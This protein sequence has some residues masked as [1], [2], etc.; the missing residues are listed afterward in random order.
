MKYTITFTPKS[1]AGRLKVPV[2][3]VE[4]QWEQFEN[5]LSNF[6]D[7]EMGELLWDELPMYAADYEIE[8]PEE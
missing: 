8:L 1:V 2:E 5:Y 7:N 4:D 3:V 6:R